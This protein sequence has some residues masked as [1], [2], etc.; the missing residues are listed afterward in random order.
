MC[1]IHRS[2]AWT[3]LLQR[4]RQIQQCGRDDP[5]CLK[6][7]LW[8]QAHHK[9]TEQPNTSHVS[10]SP[11]SKSLLAW[12]IFLWQHH[13]RKCCYSTPAAL[14]PGKKPQ[15]MHLQGYCLTAASPEHC[16]QGF[17]KFIYCS[18][19][20]NPSDTFSK[21]NTELPLVTLQH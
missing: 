17:W 20:T 4:R 19:T 15:Q 11:N 10:L 9:S 3:L 13:V 8:H 7:W 18:I 6:P 1:Q 12:V 14:E 2:T 5:T 16:P 21:Q